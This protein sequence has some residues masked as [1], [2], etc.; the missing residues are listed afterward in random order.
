[1]FA[2]PGATPGPPPYPEVF[3]S[4]GPP[5]LEGLPPRP[6]QIS[7]ASVSDVPSHQLHIN[8]Y[9]TR[10]TSQLRYED[11]NGKECVDVDCAP[12][13]CCTRKPSEKLWASPTCF[14]VG[15][16][17]NSPLGFQSIRCCPWREADSSENSFLK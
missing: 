8:K 5:L 9:Q 12:G 6:P 3:R 14:L 1:M 17:N 13:L 11:V 15:L 10:A 4:L 7:L 16:A 2:L